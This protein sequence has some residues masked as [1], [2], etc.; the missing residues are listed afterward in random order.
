M[1]IKV[2]VP[3]KPEPCLVSPPPGEF[4]AEGMTAEQ[5]CPEGY[6]CITIPTAISVGLFIGDS[7]RVASD[8][9]ACPY[10]K[11][12]DTIYTALKRYQDAGSPLP[13]E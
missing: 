1:E 9:F 3:V 10:V 13:T 11:I 2:P 8:L 5:G 7:N 4:D 12:N 6:V